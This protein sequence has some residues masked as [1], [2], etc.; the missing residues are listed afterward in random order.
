MTFDAQRPTVPSIRDGKILIVDDDRDF[1]SSLRDL[2]EPEGYE[3]A[4]ASDPEG[5][6]RIAAEFRPDVA[7]LDVKLGTANGIELIPVLKERLPDIACVVMTAS[8]ATENAEQ[9]MRNGADDFLSKPINPTDL[10]RALNRCRRHQRLEREKQEV[11]AALRDSEEETRLLLEST[12]EAIYGIDPEGN[13]TFCN[14][15]CVAMLGYNDT[16]EFLGKHMHDLIHHTRPDGTRYPAEECLIYQAFRRGEGTHVE[17]EVLWRRDGSSFPA[18]YWSYPVRRDGEVVGA[19]VTF[20]DITE[21]KR[22]ERELLNAK[23]HL[24]S[25][26]RELEE[27]AEYLVHA[28]DQAE[29]ANRAKS[30]FLAAMSH[31]LRTPLNAVIGFSEIIKNET[32]GPVGSVKYRDYASDI[33]ESGQHLLGLI[34]DILDL[35]KVESGTDE[36]HEDKIEI[37]EI[38]RSALMLVGHRAEQDGIKLELELQDPLPAL[39]ADERKLKQILVNLLS[40]AIKFTDAGGAVTLRAWCRMDSGYV[41]QITDTGI[42]IAPEDIPKALSRFSQVDADLNRQ[43]EGTGLGLPL[44]RALVEQHGGVLDLQSKIGVGTTV[45]V[46]FPAERILRSPHNAKAVNLA[47]RNVG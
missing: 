31:E 8:A 16:C 3:V 47:A 42:G 38:I 39:R 22:S 40:N 25:Q 21:R 20:L 35:S 26:S 7:L 12:A 34:N 33:H 19:V 9:A 17:D 27:M 44:T 13:C 30:E 37:P 10:M 2:L 46:R 41:F 5:A 15:A 11:V 14:S 43:Y 45:T 24:E 18:E 23:G 29:A 32:F 36:L 4:T 6:R 1:L 28:R